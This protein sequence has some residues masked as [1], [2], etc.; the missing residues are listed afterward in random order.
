MDRTTPRH[1]RVG[2][3]IGALTLLIAFHASGGSASAAAP[4]LAWKFTPGESLHYENV[5]K[6]VTELKG[7]GESISKTA[8]SQTID[9]T[10]KVQ[11]V[12]ASGAAEMTQTFD[13]F[14]VR[15]ES[16]FGLVEWDSQDGKEPVGA[17]ASGVIP[18]Y[19]PLVGAT[20]RYKMSP[21]G[22]LSDIRVP[23]GLL[24]KLKGAGITAAGMGTFSEEGLKSM[25]RDSSLVLPSDPLD[26]PWTRE[27]KTPAPPLGTQVIERTFTYEGAD[28]AS[29]AEK[30][31]MKL[32]FKLEQDPSS[33]SKVEVGSQEG[34]GSY[35]FDTRAGR[36]VSYEQTRKLQLVLTTAQNRKLTKT[37]ETEGSM[38]LVKAEK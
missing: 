23:E 15:I 9:T 14:R 27:T 3:G 5:Q 37:D 11:S 28:P 29:G 7:D 6:T 21:Q 1:A 17:V 13:R 33:R 18:G 12:D 38:K 25:I 20:F 30:V 36:V 19:K 24:D 16:P 26:K 10:W 8:V 35:L 32:V 4:R 31:G 22:E 34:R 2:R